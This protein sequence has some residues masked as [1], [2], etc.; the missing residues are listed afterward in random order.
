M[1]EEDAEAWW[2]R[3]PSKR[4]IQIYK[5]LARPTNQVEIV[6]GQLALLEKGGSNGHESSGQD[7]GHL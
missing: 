3:L 1:D 7:A 4:R 6:P 5:Y 2:N